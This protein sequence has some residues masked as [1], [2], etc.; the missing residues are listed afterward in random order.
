MGVSDSYAEFIVNTK[1]DNIPEE[2][3]AVAKE[4]ILD[5]LGVALAGAVEQPS[6]IIK[7]FVR[8]CGGVPESSIIGAGSRSSAPNAA[9]ANGTMAH[10][11]D[12][13]DILPGGHV[14][15]VVLPAVLALGE[16]LHLSGKDTLSAYIIGFEVFTRLFGAT[17]YQ[18]YGK[19]HTTALFGHLAA[20]AASAKALSLDAGQ[21][22][23]AFGIATSEASGVYGNNFTMVKAF[24]AGNT[25]KNGVTAAMLAG[26]GYQSAENMIESQFGFLNTFV[27]EGNYNLVQ[28]TNNIGAPFMIHSPGISIKK[29]PSCYWIDNA[30]DA[31]LGLIRERNLSYEQIES[32]EV[33]GAPDLPKR[34]RYSNPQDGLQAKFSMNYNMAA[35][36]LDGKVTR[37]TFED[38]KIRDQKIQEAMKKIK[39]T[40]HPEWPEG[41]KRSH[42]PVTITCK[43]GK[44]YRRTVESAKG[45]PQ[46]R[47][48]WQELVEKF[49]DN[50][51]EVLTVQQIKKVVSLVKNL[52]DIPNISQLMTMLTK[53]NHIKA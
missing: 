26:A 46:N 15:V 7:E 36:I 49:E 52:Q 21:I 13:D 23:M 45:A 14:S 20:T 39:V 4:H 6:I 27:G 12:Y 30:L 53:N 44:V 41:E 35:A 10:I 18:Q 33:E 29:Y 51:A 47:L 9:L 25:C 3:I 43:D 16:K 42:N 8:K 5:T 2:V 31:V 22:K 19:L 50:A 32:V 40:I 48:T 17:S 38:N 24:H 1:F 28:A 37:S 34:L 11:L